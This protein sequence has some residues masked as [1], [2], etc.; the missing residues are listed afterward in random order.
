ME[1]DCCAPRIHTDCRAIF[2]ILNAG[3]LRKTTPFLTEFA[4]SPAG[5]FAQIRAPSGA[6]FRS[7]LA[8]VRILNV[9]REVIYRVA[10]NAFDVA[11][12]RPTALELDEAAL[13]TPA[14]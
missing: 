6:R 12:V 8:A 7:G 9:D 4:R 2:R 3:T 13:L 1:V 5:N 14:G 11:Q 10:R